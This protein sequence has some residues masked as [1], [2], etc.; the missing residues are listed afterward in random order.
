MH[1]EDG[2]LEES[3]MRK[4]PRSASNS[5]GFE[6]N[7]ELQIAVSSDS[8]T[9]YS[10]TESEES[11]ADCRYGAPAPPLHTGYE[12][13]N[14]TYAEKS[15]LARLRANRAPA[16]STAAMVPPPPPPT[17]PPPK[18]KHQKDSSRGD[19]SQSNK[20]ALISL[21]KEMRSL[22]TSFELERASLQ[23]TISEQSQQISALEKSNR[24]L[25]H[26]NS[27][28]HEGMNTVL[29][30]L[31]RFATGCWKFSSPSVKK[32]SEALHFQ[33]VEWSRQY[34]ADNSHALCSAEEAAAMEQTTLEK[35]QDMHMTISRLKKER[36]DLREKIKRYNN[37]KKRAV[38]DDDETSHFS[39]ITMM[40]AATSM[41]ATTNVSSTTKLSSAMAKLLVDSDANQQTNQPMKQSH[42]NRVDIVASGRN[43]AKGTVPRPILKQ[44]S[45]YR[46]NSSRTKSSHNG[47]GKIVGK[48]RGHHSKRRQNIINHGASEIDSFDDEESEV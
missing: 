46:T 16:S 35:V 21:L 22:E 19:S 27:K 10:Q 42:P 40:T 6:R 48:T 26:E 38:E 1:R 17:S 5:V 24:E 32:L 30:K 37:R 25:K 29:S 34:G 23:S 8:Q 15:T 9:E 43:R 41:S 39:G 47:G 3:T 2:R 31:D 28:L 45:R 36:I 14:E 13:F 11:M 18:M 20:K 44:S 12:S 33:V 7:D 4:A